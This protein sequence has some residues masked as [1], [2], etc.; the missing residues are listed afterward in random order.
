MH[1]TLKN[2]IHENYTFDCNDFNNAPGVID[3]SGITFYYTSTPRQHRAGI[4]I[5][6]HVVAQLMVIPPNAANYTVAGLC[7]GQCTDAVSKEEIVS[8]LH[9]CSPAC[10]GTL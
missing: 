6:G 1:A 7:P 8:C 9:L 2:T 3:S 4:M 5:L 10:T